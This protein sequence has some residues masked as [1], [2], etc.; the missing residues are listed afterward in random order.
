[1]Q[2]ELVQ[3]ES[4][5]EQLEQGWQELVSASSLNHPFL[6]WDWCTTWWRHYGCERRCGR[7]DRITRPDSA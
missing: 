7:A 4:R 6:Q 5:L 3:N 2:I 1:M